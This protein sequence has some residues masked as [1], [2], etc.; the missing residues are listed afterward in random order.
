MSTRRRRS[1][2]AL[3]EFSQH[4]GGVEQLDLPWA[5]FVDDRT[6]DREFEVP[7]A[8]A[9]DPYVTIQAYDVGVYGHEIL[10]NGET[11]SGFDL[12]PA[13]GWQCWMDFLAGTELDEGS[14]TV[15]IARDEGTDDSF[16]VGSV[17]VTWREPVD[18]S[19]APGS[20][21]T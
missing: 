4:L 12:P 13:D 16:A 8:N 2:Y 7:T 21:G 3:V 1:N 20:E 6:P 19:S 5:E 17:R 14:N 10:I 15:A 18:T 11:V 9:I